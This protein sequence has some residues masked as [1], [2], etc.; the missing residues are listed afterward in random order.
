VTDNYGSGAAQPPYDPRNPYA[1]PGLTP[2][3]GHQP[4][5]GQQEAAPMAS[6]QQLPYGTPPGYGPAP[7]YG[8]QQPYGPQPGY[9]PAPAYGQPQLYQGQPDAGRP[10]AGQTPAYPQ[11]PSYPAPPYG[12][13]PFAGQAPYGQY[14][15]VPL[16]AYLPPQR[17]GGKTG[18]LIAG[19]TAAALIISVVMVV[20]LSPG[21]KA[22]TPGSGASANAAPTNGRHAAT[23][24]ADLVSGKSGLTASACPGPGSGPFKL[25]QPAAVC[26]IPISQ[27]ADFN[28]IAQTELQGAELAFSDPGGFGNYTNGLAFQAMYPNFNSP[29]PYL[30]IQVFGFNGTFTNVSAAVKAIE[31]D[32]FETFYTVPAGPHGGVMQCAEDTTDETQECVFGTSTTLGD[33]QFA[34]QNLSIPA[35]ISADASAISVRDAIEAPS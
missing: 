31:S 17:R 33:I 3:Y 25:V 26:G 11:P 6:G 27:N 7:G 1:Q 24:P 29:G 9:T 5:Q 2:G 13:Q 12:Q 19:V 8:Q 28:Q 34:F 16:P 30:S 32:D 14:G 22:G 4:H 15:P 20:T 10:D 35:G 18:W 23:E 21:P